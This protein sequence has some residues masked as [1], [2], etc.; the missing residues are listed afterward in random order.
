M[1]P[2]MKLLFVFVSMWVLGDVAG[3]PYIKRMYFA[4]M[5]TI[6]VGYIDNVHKLIWKYLKEH[7]YKII[8][9]QR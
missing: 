8:R 9:S 3:T 6:G 1:N 7:Y 4:L 2:G 5:M